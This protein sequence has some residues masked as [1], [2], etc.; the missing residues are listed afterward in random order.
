MSKCKTVENTTTAGKLLYDCIGDY[1][2]EMTI[3][4]AS[5][6]VYALR[7]ISYAL[8]YLTEHLQN[9]ISR[10]AKSENMH[11]VDRKQGDVYEQ[12]DKV[13]NI[14]KQ[15]STSARILGENYHSALD[16]TAWIRD[17]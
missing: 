9:E 8:T 16:Y 3:T 15:S 12:L 17:R 7:D 2:Q 1:K 6:T 5:E 14:L 13:Q 10:N 11:L 4:E